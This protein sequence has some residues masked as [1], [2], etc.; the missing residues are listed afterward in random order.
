[1]AGAKPKRRRSVPRN[2]AQELSDYLQKTLAGDETSPSGLSPLEVS[3]VLG[4]L[5]GA[6]IEVHAD[7]HPP[8][9]FHVHSPDFDAAFAI[10]DCRLVEGELPGRVEGQVREWYRQNKP[11]AVAGW[12]AMRPSDCSVGRV[13]DK[14]AK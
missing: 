7:E 10:D 14:P 12:N 2:Y 9:H 11:V 6:K 1:M 3:R 5:G 13:R 8:P 4:Q